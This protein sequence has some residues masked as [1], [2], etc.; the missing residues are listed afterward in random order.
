MLMIMKMIIMMTVK[1]AHLIL[2]LDPTS[3]ASKVAERES[4]TVVCRC[5]GRSRLHHLFINQHQSIGGHHHHLIWPMTFSHCV[6]H[7]AC[8]GAYLLIV[9]LEDCV[10]SII[11]LFREWTLT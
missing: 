4:M 8:H 1:P 3:R 7:H 5:M 10:A 6:L 11:H 9:T 2:T